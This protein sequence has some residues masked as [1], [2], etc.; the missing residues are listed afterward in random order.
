MRLPDQPGRNAAIPMPRSLKQQFSVGLPRPLSPRNRRSLAAQTAFHIPSFA[1][2]LAQCRSPLPLRAS[3]LRGRTWAEAAVSMAAGMI[4]ALE[5]A[6]CGLQ[7]PSA[8]QANQQ[9]W[10]PDHG[11]SGCFSRRETAK[12]AFS[13]DAGRLR[14]LGAFRRR[15]DVMPGPASGASEAGLRM[16]GGPLAERRGCFSADGKRLYACAGS[17]IR[18]YRCG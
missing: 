10:S 5:K 16:V 11:K 4:W 2:P 13:A 6:L 1:F 9:T 14:A 3:V 15:P 8:A 18:A 12:S 7:A 17:T